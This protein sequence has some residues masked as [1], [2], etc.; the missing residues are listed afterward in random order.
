MWPHTILPGLLLAATLAAI[1]PDE[2]PRRLGLN[3]GFG[4]GGVS[5]VKFFAVCGAW[6]EVSTGKTA[7]FVGPTSP[8]SSRSWKAFAAGG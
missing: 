3:A 5:H 1:A 6:G 7:L 2:T 4:A 8:S